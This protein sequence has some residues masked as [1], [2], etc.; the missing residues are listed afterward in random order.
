MNGRAVGANNLQFFVYDFASCP[1][2]CLHRKTVGSDID[3]VSKYSKAKLVLCRTAHRKIRLIRAEHV[4]E[5]GISP[6]LVALGVQRHADPDRRGVNEGRE[7][8]NAALQLG[9]EVFNLLLR[10]PSIR[11]IRQ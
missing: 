9:I 11:N 5:L 2:G 10:P 1:A 8:D 4:D 3:S 6:D 7:L